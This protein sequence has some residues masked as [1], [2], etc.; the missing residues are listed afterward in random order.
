MTNRSTKCLK[1]ILFIIVFA[2]TINFNLNNGSGLNIGTISAAAFLASLA[3][4]IATLFGFVLITSG[5][6]I[7]TIFITVALIFFLAFNMDKL[8]NAIPWLSDDLW[9]VIIIAAGIICVMRDLVFIKRSIFGVRRAGTAPDASPIPKEQPTM[10]EDEQSLFEFR[11]RIK[12][13]P[14][15]VLNISNYLEMESGRK[16]TYEEIT[17]FIDTLE[18]PPEGMFS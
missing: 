1:I 2:W 11:E 18:E 10:T 13:D 12:K 17:A 8:T 3:Y 6:Y 16:P 15:S 14:Q 4:L 7:I 5:N 9:M